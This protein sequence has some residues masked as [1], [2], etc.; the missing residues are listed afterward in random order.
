VRTANTAIA[1]AA[2][3]FAT[4]CMCIVQVR[5]P[6]LATLSLL[7][8]WTLLA[9]I[10]HKQTDSTLL[11][12]SSSFNVTPPKPVA[13]STATANNSASTHNTAAAD[14]K[15]A[16]LSNSSSSNSSSNADSRTTNTNN[17]STTTTTA[18]GVNSSGK[19]TLKRERTRSFSDTVKDLRGRHSA[20]KLRLLDA[21]LLLALLPLGYLA[22]QWYT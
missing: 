16:I 17:G 2:L 7:G 8:L 19:K 9:Y 14:A 11:Q 3:K 13:N 10:T 4:P 6:W 5:V 22:R 1:S 20:T 21:L 18:A 15:R 12:R